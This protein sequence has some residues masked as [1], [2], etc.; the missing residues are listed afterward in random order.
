MSLSLETGSGSPGT[1]ASDWNGQVK[2]GPKYRKVSEII[3]ILHCT[4]D[5]IDLSPTCA[6]NRPDGVL[7]ECEALLESMSPHVLIEEVRPCEV[8]HTTEVLVVWQEADV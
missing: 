3:K 4:H 7:I 8:K 5:I 6:A 1:P 2:N